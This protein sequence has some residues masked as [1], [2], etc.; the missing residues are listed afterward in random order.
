ME[1]SSPCPLPRKNLVA[2]PNEKTHIHTHV[3][4]RTHRHAHCKYAS[5]DSE[6]RSHFFVNIRQG[7]NM[8]CERASVRERE[9]TE[10]LCAAFSMDGA[11]IPAGHA[12][13]PCRMIASLCRGRTEEGRGHA[14]VTA[15]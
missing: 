2:R 13:T 12:S 9:K 1:G 6:S 10:S 7:K 11:H 3:H 14:T 4:T 5:K 15:L 8:M